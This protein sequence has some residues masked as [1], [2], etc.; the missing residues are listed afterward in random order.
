[1]TQGSSRSPLAPVAV[2]VWALGFVWSLGSGMPGADPAPAAWAEPSPK[3]PTAPAERP[4]LEHWQALSRIVEI[5][6]CPPDL[7][8]ALRTMRGFCE[9]QAKSPGPTN[10]RPRAAATT[11]GG[12]LPLAACSLVP[13]AD[14]IREL[15]NNLR[16]DTGLKL[17]QRL[18]L[19][20]HAV[21]HFGESMS[22]P[23]DREDRLRELTLGPLL[24][25]TRFLLI[26]GDGGNRPSAEERL[27]LV[28][29]LL[30]QDFQVPESQIERPWKWLL[31]KGGDDLVYPVFD[32]PNEQEPKDLTRSVYVLRIDCR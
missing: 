30:I 4:T 20:P 15:E 26:T 13:H 21:V 27:A 7:R 17:K 1:M 31:A 19:L 22:L 6:A 32:Q 16:M 2:F 24:S 8:H 23:K 10:H 29:Q 11:K 9:D 5:L 25:M 12:G 3:A 28:R 18:Q 14:D